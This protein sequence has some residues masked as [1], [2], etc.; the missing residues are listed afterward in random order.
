MRRGLPRGVGG[1]VDVVKSPQHATAV[2]LL[3]YGAR[4]GRGRGASLRQGDGSSVGEKF[5]GWIKE[6]F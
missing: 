1:L 2:G 6:L 5:L 3:H 4:Q